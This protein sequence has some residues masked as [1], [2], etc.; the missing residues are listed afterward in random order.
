MASCVAVNALQP[1]T[2]LAYSASSGGAVGNGSDGSG[3]WLTAA[4]RWRA[5][6][7]IGERALDG[8]LGARACVWFSRLSGL[9]FA[10]SALLAARSLPGT[11]DAILRLALLN[12]SWCAGLAAL[13]AAGPG[14]GRLLLAGRGLW[15]NRGVALERAQAAQPLASATWIMR[16]VGSMALLVSAVCVGA[17]AEPWRTA[18]LLGAMLGA[19]GYVAVLA[20]GLAA[21]ARLCQL[22]GRGRGQSLLLG[23]IFLPELIAPAWPELPTV[24][25]SY[26]RLLD[27]CLS[28]GARL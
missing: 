27:A 6:T 5:L 16:Q 17:S 9:G 1:E 4:R 3:G 12:L 18:R 19:L 26:A 22:L 7:R 13:S 15:Q 23:L 11:L 25:S 2:S 20:L 28:I 24:I 10:L 21:L 8:C 14:P